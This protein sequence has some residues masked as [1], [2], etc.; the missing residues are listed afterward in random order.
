MSQFKLLTKMYLQVS[1][2]NVKYGKKIKRLAIG[3]FMV[4]IG[5]LLVAFAMGSSAYMMINSMQALGV[6]EVVLFQGGILVLL[7]ETMMAIMRGVGTGTSVDAEM[8]LS[9][10]LKRSMI[11]LSKS[12]VKYLFELAICA[13]IFLPYVVSY[14]ILID[15]SVL[16][17]LRGLLV[18]L[19]I[20]LL[21]VG[22]AYVI[23]F[24]FFHLGSKISNPQMVSSVLTV[25]MVLGLMYYMLSGGNS[26]GETAAEALAMM[27][28]F[29]PAAWLVEFITKGSLLHLLYTLAI[30]ALPFAVGVRLYASI[31]GVKQKAFRSKKAALD[32]TSRSP[33]RSL[34]RNEGQRYVSSS[35]YLVNTI[36]GPVLLLIFTAVL[37]VGGKDG[38]I[39]RILFEPSLA[40]LAPLL[41][42]AAISAVMATTYISA[43]SI[44]LEG[45][46]LWLLRTL[47]V[48]T[49]DIFAAKVS[50]HVLIA[51]TPALLCTT[52]L[53]I[54]FQ[55]SLLESALMIV[56]PLL[57]I[58]M[59]AMLGLYINL[60][61]PKLNWQEEVQVVKQSMAGMLQL[62][63]GALLS[64]LPLLLYFLLFPTAT[65]LQ[66]GLLWAVYLVVLIVV[67]ALL[68]QK[69]GRKRFSQLSV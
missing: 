68:L 43:C 40:Q 5:A 33:F 47:P 12:T 39:G 19:L 62:F 4:A 36:I 54:V 1:W 7:L 51:G 15:P 45:K 35:A 32:F 61:L 69:D 57:A 53:C 50:F 66:V 25:L 24:C 26:Y 52:L 29:A 48:A 23:G 34:L 21:A 44:S 22:V 18:V 14:F 11:L 17:L 42:V 37:L 10:P 2:G 28:S 9:L 8:L 41:I 46:R 20:P 56:L 27:Q 31:Y 64:I 65:A 38:A 67:L 55:F 13:V 16:F 49:R 3:G 60:L 59:Q 6:P 30:T 58:V 63:L